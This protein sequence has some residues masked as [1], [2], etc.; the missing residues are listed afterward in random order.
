[1]TVGI[2]RIAD[3][4]PAERKRRDGRALLL[5][6][7]RQL[8]A[9]KGYAGME[10]RD[11]AE[12]GKAPRGSIY[13]HFP[14][15]KVQLAREAAELEGTTIRDLIERSLEQRGLKQTLTLFGDVFRRRVADYPERIG[16]PVAAVALARPEDPGLA[17]AATAA[18]QS[19][20]RPIAAALR[21]EGVSAKDAET[22]AGLVV[23]TVEGAL[24][25]ARAAGS[26]EPLDSAM[27]GLG[28]ALDRLLEG[29]PTSP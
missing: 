26:Q 13:H 14:G 4:E 27:G 18:F 9:E 25:R 3:G 5:K 16:C 6:G 2:A 8:L 1:M 17:A 29:S 23:S 20:E 12:R 15:G 11:V 21:D 22:F 19:W 7:A 28:H 10:L 24:L